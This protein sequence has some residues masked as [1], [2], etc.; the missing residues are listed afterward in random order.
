MPDALRARCRFIILILH[1]STVHFAHIKE[2]VNHLACVEMWTVDQ[3]GGGWVDR[4]LG[5]G[6]LASF[7]PLLKYATGGTSSTDT[8]QCSVKIRTNWL[9]Y[10]CNENGRGYISTIKDLMSQR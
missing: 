4:G 7:W 2:H 8:G 5:R 9:Y 1:K 10:K 3:R 6:G